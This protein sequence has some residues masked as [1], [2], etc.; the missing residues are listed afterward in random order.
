MSRTRALLLGI[1][2][3]IPALWMVVWFGYFAYGFLS[4]GP[5][6]AFDAMFAGM[7]ADFVLTVAL[8]VFYVRHALHND[9][10]VGD[11]R[12]V[13]T[14]FLIALNAFSQPVYWF[15][16]IWRTGGAVGPAGLA[17]SAEPRQRQEVWPQQS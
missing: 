9:R 1:V 16:Y 10:L 5:W 14:I 17:A 7:A 13:W 15:R 8:C 2:T 3:A 11:E 6:P 12:A 4:S